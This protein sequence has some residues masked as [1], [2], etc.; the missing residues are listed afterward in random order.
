[1]GLVAAVIAGCV[2]LAV[3]IIFAI[4]FSIMEKKASPDSSFLLLF[5]D[6]VFKTVPLV[7]VGT[8]FLIFWWASDNL[9]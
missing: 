8:F 9:Y 5:F 4:A 7:A 2:G 6:N 1:M 3:G